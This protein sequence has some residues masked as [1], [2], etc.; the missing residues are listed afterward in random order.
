MS[1]RYKPT[2]G[3]RID[4]LKLHPSIGNCMCSHRR[5]LR[6]LCFRLKISFPNYNQHDHVTPSTLSPPTQRHQHQS[7]LHT[8]RTT[9]RTQIDESCVAFA[10][11]FRGGLSICASARGLAELLAS[12]E[13][14]GSGANGKGRCPKQIVR[15]IW[16]TCDTKQHPALQNILKSVDFVE[17]LLNVIY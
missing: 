16:A 1:N 7:D 15:S 8:R 11:R 9:R 14:N 13:P 2:L 10:R 6:N 3:S 17:A 4:L 5:S 12:E